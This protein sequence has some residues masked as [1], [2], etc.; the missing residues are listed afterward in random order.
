MQDIINR[1][2]VRI[3]FL[4][5]SLPKIEK[6]AALYM[7]ENMEQIKEM[8]LAEYSEA[9]GCSEASV[10][11]FCRK[12]GVDG[13]AE[14][15]ELLLDGDP[16]ENEAIKY[17]EVHPEDTMY[18]I[19]QKVFYCNIQTLKDTL[20]LVSDDYDAAL[21][22]ISNAKRICFFCI[23]DAVVPCMLA[24]NKFMRLGMICT[25]DT[26]ADMQLITAANLKPGD[27]AIAISYSGRTRSVVEAMKLAKKNGATTICIT[28]MEKSP[29]IRYCQ[30]KLFTATH[31]I[32]AG[33]EIVARRIA[34]QA[35]MEAL[36]LGLINKGKPQYYDNM[37][38][39]TSALE[40]N[41]IP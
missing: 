22:A 31:D 5:P 21:A 11:R 41:K 12:L 2:Q 20:A 15:K 6:K 7:L 23:G 8:T 37:C 25:V 29:L 1:F 4:L 30:I 3:R 40:F 10:L 32:S 13:Y 16:N 34:E 14:L 26:D 33:K 28:K 19:L 24:Q 36:Y 9:S 35:I 38:K 17:Q 27:V 18:E 39:T